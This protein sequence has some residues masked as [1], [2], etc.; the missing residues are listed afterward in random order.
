MWSQLQ[1]RHI[2]VNA[3]KVNFQGTMCIGICGKK[4]QRWQ[5]IKLAFA[6]SRALHSNK[7]ASDKDFND[8]LIQGS[9]LLNTTFE[10]M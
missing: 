1:D 8:L 2:Q 7:K 6:L 3:G 9:S 5:A 4:K 10:V